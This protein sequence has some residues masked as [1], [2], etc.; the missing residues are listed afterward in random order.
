MSP[1][2]GLPH[3]NR[4]GDFDVFAL[5]VILRETGKILDEV[6]D[7]PGQPVGPG[8]AQRRGLRLRDIEAAAAEGDARAELAIDVFIAVDPPLPR[9][10]SARAGRGRCDRLHRRDRR[11]LGADSRGRLPRA[12][13][14]R[15]RARS[16]LRTPAGRPSGWSR[17]PARACRSGRVPTNEE[18]VVAR[19]AKQLLEQSNEKVRSRCSWPE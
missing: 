9:C 4:V 12:G 8:R 17:R 16:R 10:V 13:L 15:H 2:S 7:D 18:I 3:N 14:V 1:Q 11:E 5:P 19:Q 6:L